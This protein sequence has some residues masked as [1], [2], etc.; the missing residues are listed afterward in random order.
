MSP[1]GSDEPAPP[2][3]AASLLLLRDHASGLEVFLLERPDTAS[4]ATGAT[5]FPGGKVEEDDLDPELGRFCRGAQGL[6]ERELGLRVAA[7]RETYEE[8]GV[9][10]AR[11]RGSE[12][13]IGSDRMAAIEERFGEA[14]ASHALELSVLVR[15][16]K[17]ELACDQ[18]V[19]FSHWVTPVIVPR[20]FDTHFFAAAMPPDQEAAHDG[21]ESVG[22]LWLEPA[23]APAA[24]K[25]GERTL[26]FPTLM[27]LEAVGASQSADQALARARNN[28]VVRVLPEVVETAEGRRLRIPAEA[29][30][31]VT[32][33]PA[34]EPPSPRK[35]N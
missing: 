1:S 24:A 14:R 7:I 6:E 23:A 18:L 29:G 35:R 25:S 3:L 21:R 26:M 28:T 12:A 15:E 13:L 8:A 34:P 4:F 5:V 31:S 30:Y 9:L 2:I 16:E 19:H 17:L 22:S 27:N 33:V 11:E 10:L 32:E 20:R